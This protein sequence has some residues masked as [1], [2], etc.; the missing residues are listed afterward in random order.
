VTIG[1]RFQPLRQELFVFRRIVD[2]LGKRCGPSF[3]RRTAGA[4]PKFEVRH[5]IIPAMAELLESR[6][7]LSL[8]P[9]NPNDSIP[10]KQ[11]VIDENPGTG[12]VV[13]L[14]ANLSNQGHED[15]I[16]GHETNLGGGGLYWYQ[17][18]SD[19]NPNET[20]TKYT[21]D[22]NAD[23]YEAA[24]AAD[25]SGHSDANGNPVNDLVVNENGTIVW[26]E[27]PLGDGVDPTTV[28]SWT[29]HVIGTIS[30]GTSHELYLADLLGNGLLDVVTNTSIF[31]QNSPGNWNQI[32]T[33][34]YNRTEKGLS[35]FD[36][37]SGNGAV[38]LLGTGPGPSY[39]VGWYENP[40]D[41][42]GN[43]ETDPWYFHPI[44]P[45][46]GNYV[47]GDGVSY[48]A[49]DVNGDGREDIVTCDGEYAS[50]DGDDGTNAGL[51]LTG[52]LIWWQAPADRA[53]GTWIPH[54]IDAGVTDVHNLVIADMNGDGTP[55]IL[56]F[57]QD[58]SPQGRLMVVYNEGGTGQN[59]LEQTLASDA[60]PAAGGGE[61]G[62]NESV[63]DATG[64]GTLDILTSPHGFF[65]QVNPISLYLN[66][67]RIDG[68]VRP[69]ITNSPGSQAVNAGGRATFSVSAGGTGP[70]TYQWQLNGLNIP[71][72]TGSSYTINAV[73]Q[74]DNGGLFR[75]VVGNGAG[76]IPSAGATLKVSNNGTGSFSGNLFYDQNAD[77][78]QDG[79]DAGLAG[80]TV[81]LDLNNDATPDP[82]DPTTITNS[83][84]GYV[85]TGLAAGTYRVGVVLP[86]G[87]QVTTNSGAIPAVTV[88]AGQNTAAAAIGNTFNAIS[89]FVF[90]DT[91]GNGIQ[92]SGEGP[93]IGQELFIDIN[94]DGKLDA[95]DPTATTD[96][97]GNY[98]F[99]GIAAGT[100]AVDMVIPSGSHE[101]LPP[102]GG[103]QTV[104]VGNVPATSINFAIAAGGPVGGI[105][106]RL[107]VD[108]QGSGRTEG[109]VGAPPVGQRVYLDLANSGNYQAGDPTTA[110]DAK[111]DYFFTNLADGTYTVRFVPARGYVQ[112][113]PAGN[114][115]QTV[116]VDGQTV[117][118]VALGE[119]KGGAT[120]SANIPLA[121]E[122]SSKTP[123]AAIGGAKERVAVRITNSNDTAYR[124]PLELDLYLCTDNSI[125]ADAVLAQ[126]TVIKKGTLRKG[127][128]TFN[129]RYAV[130]ATVRSGNYYLLSSVSA[131][132]VSA[133]S[134]LA[135]AIAASRA[136]IAVS[137]PF[138][139]FS[140][141]VREP[142][143]ALLTPGYQSN[144]A[145]TLTNMGNIESSG[146]VTVDV[147]ASASG[148][149]DA[150]SILVDAF[151]STLKLAP[152]H[153]RTLRASFIP[154][155]N[156]STGDYSVLARA[157]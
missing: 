4:R 156:I 96:A 84:G 39:D 66:E 88:A 125:D 17:F 115:G 62:H 54:T 60:N 151:T 136:T 64:D 135:P 2:G 23:V 131:G 56:A 76:L 93:A 110:T 30:Q 74:S 108:P 32:S 111:G 149:L 114:G 5:P 79:A 46:Y 69:T 21:I 70:L 20:W 41:H 29:K 104:T 154:S 68:I 78:T 116:V 91:N 133:A 121:A 145:V 142:A 44:G 120:G 148:T 31:F 119:V 28:T 82:G 71:G 24:R 143:V 22:A 73:P 18:P 112:N 124:G 109:G 6:C 150:N 144:A 98:R 11:I 113:Y 122:I 94:G 129:L 57:E 27:N 89:G 130:P 67:R 87:W 127:V 105:D 132:N 59:W 118:G 72:S 49:L 157:T 138:V 55:E 134:D 37:G 19:G 36:S 147:Y 52:G 25:I 53:N 103:G 90:S 3:R 128:A 8:T 106:G 95:G 140:A 61:G 126:T 102:A 141:I 65:T 99:T 48:A 58:Q 14:L 117:E 63:G 9:L 38:D 146:E 51:D 81:Y 92:D 13:K 80:R 12:P 86:Q 83:S 34:N 15:A 137:A 85:F 10:F 26:Y 16:V 153:F 97:N 123:A 45:A 35:L 7:L 107:V 40:R 43:A 33:A 42:G 77:G 152:G 155:A 75:C 47:A 50:G 101:S 139:S 100:Y 1:R